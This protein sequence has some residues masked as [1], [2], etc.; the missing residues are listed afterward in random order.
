MEDTKKTHLVR[1]NIIYDGG[2]VEFYDAIT[3]V[4]VGCCGINWWKLNAVVFDPLGEQ[5]LP[6]WP[7]IQP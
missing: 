7:T 1:P 4:Y 2:M 3:D 5:K 6:V